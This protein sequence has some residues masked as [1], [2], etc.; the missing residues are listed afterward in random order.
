MPLPPAEAPSS[1]K[2]RDDRASQRAAVRDHA[3]HKQGLRN[4]A[5]R[6]QAMLEKTRRKKPAAAKGSHQKALRRDMQV[7][8]FTHHVQ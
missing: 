3:Q 7:L 6:D 8:I 1:K 5:R 4:Q 2:Q